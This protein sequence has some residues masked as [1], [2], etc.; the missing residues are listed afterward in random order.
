M[1]GM[2]EPYVTTQNIESKTVE[3]LERIGA[4]NRHVMELKP[5]NSALLV[6]DMQNFFLDPASPSFTCGGTAILPAVKRLVAAF[7]RASRP[8]I[9]T[10]HVHHPANLDSGIMQWWWEGMCLEGSPDSEIHPELA[11][12]PNEKVVL[13]HRYSAFYNTDLETVL[14]CLK[15]EDLVI[16]GVMTNMCCESTARDAYFRDYRVFFPADANGSINEEMHLASL[17]NLAFG[18]AYVTNS[19]SIVSQIDPDPSHGKK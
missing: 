19:G 17:I 14:R 16:T 9:F 6:I 3:W 18:F 5:G 1:T 13:K 8:V 7:R 15:V 11:S 4:C 2:T 12:L 10:R